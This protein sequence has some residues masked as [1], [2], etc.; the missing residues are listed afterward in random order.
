MGIV[1]FRKAPRADRKVHGTVW[2]FVGI[3]DIELT[4]NLS[5]LR[6]RL[7]PTTIAIS[8]A[9]WKIVGWTTETKAENYFTLITGLWFNAC[10]DENPSKWPISLEFMRLKL[11]KRLCC[12]VFFMFPF[13][14][15]FLRSHSSHDFDIQC[16]GTRVTREFIP[17]PWREIFL[18]IFCYQSP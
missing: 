6:Q 18:L 7:Q 9:K 16:T 15:R 3:Q 13:G 4:L 11:G 17:I 8:A 10:Q 14:W 12:S 1:G 5:Y 2:K